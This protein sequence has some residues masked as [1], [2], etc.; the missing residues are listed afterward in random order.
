MTEQELKHLRLE[1]L[2]RRQKRPTV[3]KHTVGNTVFEVPAHLETK[4]ATWGAAQRRYDKDYSFDLFY[5]Q[6]PQPQKDL[7]TLI[8]SNK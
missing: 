1:A 7:V 3:F 5:K 4:F 8:H 2:G 6:L